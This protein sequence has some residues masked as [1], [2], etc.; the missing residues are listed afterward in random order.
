MRREGKS[1]PPEILKARF[2]MNKKLH[3]KDRKQQKTGWRA[4]YD[5]Q[6]AFLRE[7]EEINRL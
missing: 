1:P 6:E 3:E 4:E 7:L 5:L 2:A